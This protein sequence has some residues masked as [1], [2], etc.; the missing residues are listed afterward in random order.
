LKEEN[1]HFKYLFYRPGRPNYCRPF[2]YH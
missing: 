2:T 1:F